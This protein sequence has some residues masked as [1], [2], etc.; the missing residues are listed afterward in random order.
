MGEIATFPLLETV[1]LLLQLIVCSRDSAPNR[2]KWSLSSSGNEITGIC[3]TKKKS[4]ITGYF[5]VL[6][7]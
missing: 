7:V 2:Q 3:I 1:S 5:Y 4:N 6:N